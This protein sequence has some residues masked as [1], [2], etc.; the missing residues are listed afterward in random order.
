MLNLLLFWLMKT[1]LKFLPLVTPL[2]F[3]HFFYGYNKV[4]GKISFSSEAKALISTCND[5][6]PFPPGCYYANGEFHV[7][8]DIAEVSTIVEEPLAEISGHIRR[9]LERAVKKTS[10][11]RC[12]NGLSLVRWFRFI[13]GLC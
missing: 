3:V 13:I 2:G 12:S 4:T 11:C 1:L 5:V 9:K 8:N 6:T 7:F 10:S